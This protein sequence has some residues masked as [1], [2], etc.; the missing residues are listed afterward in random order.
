MVIKVARDEHKIDVNY[1]E[2]AFWNQNKNK[3]LFCHITDNCPHYTWI[4][5]KYCNKASNEFKIYKEKINNSGYYI[6]DLHPDNISRLNESG[7]LVCF[8]Y[9]NAAKI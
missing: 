4:E 3:K 9:P 6:E 2:A 7:E 1:D 8:D 5:M